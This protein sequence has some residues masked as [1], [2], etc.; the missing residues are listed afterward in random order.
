[1]TTTTRT[2]GRCAA[3]G[4]TNPGRRKAIR[5]GAGC[6]HLVH[7][8]VHV[9]ERRTFVVSSWAEACPEHCNLVAAAV[10]RDVQDW[11]DRWAVQVQTLNYGPHAAGAVEEVAQG[12]GTPP[13]GDGRL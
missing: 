2:H 10:Q 11:P 7:G 12:I 1:M 3:D 5:A 4:C 13:D 8:H 9:E 6:W